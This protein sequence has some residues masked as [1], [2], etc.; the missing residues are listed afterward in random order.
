MERQ[1]RANPYKSTNSR[2]GS[3]SKTPGSDSK[4]V[5]R[6]PVVTDVR[7]DRAVADKGKGVYNGEARRE[8]IDPPGGK[9]NK[10]NV[11]NVWALDTL[12]LNVQ[13]GE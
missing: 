2:Y 9:S 6:S 8:P 7:V 5:E 3:S 11:S 10:S 12:L 13:T 4:S 1:R